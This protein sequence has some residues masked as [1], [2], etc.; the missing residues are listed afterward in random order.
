MEDD[1]AFFMS[2]SKPLSK[3][4][5]RRSAGITVILFN[6]VIH[7]QYDVVCPQSV[8]MPAFFDLCVKP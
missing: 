7:R 3:Q 4:N 1:K 2:I 5:A 6:I 8:P